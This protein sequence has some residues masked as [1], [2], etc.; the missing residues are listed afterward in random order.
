MM[1][2]DV[3]FRQDI[4]SIIHGNTLMGILGAMSGD[5][6]NVDFVRGL[7]VA[8]KG[9]CTAFG[10]DWGPMRDDIIAGAKHEDVD[11]LPVVLT[12]EVGE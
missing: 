9:A 7:L 8:A 11:L 5:S 12:L 4:A 2:L 6:P 3:W 1:A 10:I